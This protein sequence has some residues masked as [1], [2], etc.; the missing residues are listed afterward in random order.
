VIGYT[1]RIRKLNRSADKKN[2]GVRLGRHCIDQN[3][4]VSELM[5]LLGVSKQTIYNWFIGASD[6]LNIMVATIKQFL[7]SLNK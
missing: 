1:Y 3:I 6:P 4:S 5:G 2:I 7:A